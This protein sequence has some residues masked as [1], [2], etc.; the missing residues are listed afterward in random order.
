MIRLRYRIYGLF[1]LV[2][3]ACAPS[4]LL[5]Q[6]TST[7][8][9]PTGT[10]ITVLI[11]PA[12]QIASPVT[13]APFCVSGSTPTSSL[14]GCTLA[15]RDQRSQFCTNKVPYTLITLPQGDTY[16]V[17]TAGF[18]CTPA[19]LK[20]NLQLL[21]C[22]GSPSSRFSLQV[23]NPICALAVTP[24]STVQAGRCSPGYDYL[25][26]QQCCQ[27]ANSNQSGCVTLSYDTAPCG[28]VDCARIKDLSACTA[29]SSCKWIIATKSKPA[30]C[31]LK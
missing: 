28:L 27:V 30:Y 29:K 16:S 26:D 14:S 12:T 19:G 21:T 1:V 23:C 7:I 18:T 20:D 13:Q 6:P 25:P 11:A 4:G 15:T 10:P 22:S 17:L 2:I 8:T 24:A 9:T 5:P 31:T 3:L